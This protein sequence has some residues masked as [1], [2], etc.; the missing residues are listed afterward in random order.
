MLWW[1]SRI[2]HAIA[3]RMQSPLRTLVLIRAGPRKPKSDA[4]PP[5]VLIRRKDAELLARLRCRI[6]LSAPAFCGNCSL[7]SPDGS[8]KFPS[9]LLVHVADD[10][11]DG[12]WNKC[13]SAISLSVQCYLLPLA[14]ISPIAAPSNL[15]TLVLLALTPQRVVKS[16]SLDQKRCNCNCDQDRSCIPPFQA[17]ASLR[18][19]CVSVPSGMAISES[20]RQCP[21]CAH[22]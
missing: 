22:D 20:L 14:G 1:P 18:L 19:D 15:P 17:F 9:Q 10:G 7:L 3:V 8:A 13:L 6:R 11:S 4:T 12:S 16:C 2:G 21:P 5:R